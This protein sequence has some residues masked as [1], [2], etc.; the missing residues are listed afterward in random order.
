MASLAT[1]QGTWLGGNCLLYLVN[2]LLVS[3]TYTYIK[4]DP[5]IADISRLYDNV[6]RHLESQEYENITLINVA[7]KILR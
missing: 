3:T 7:W 5:A 1:Y 2:G 4:L 6:L